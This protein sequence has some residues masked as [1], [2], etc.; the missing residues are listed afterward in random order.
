MSLPINYM[1]RCQSHVGEVCQ[2]SLEEEG[3]LKRYKKQLDNAVTMEFIPTDRNLPPIVLPLGNGRRFIYVSRVFGINGVGAFLRLYAFGW[4]ATV[5]GKNVKHMIWVYP[6]G[7]VEV[8]EEPIMVEQILKHLP[9]Y[10]A[11]QS[12]QERGQN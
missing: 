10:M 8:S 9:Q 12:L 2:F 11:Q 7:S 5:D 1:L 3:W 4:Q 6:N